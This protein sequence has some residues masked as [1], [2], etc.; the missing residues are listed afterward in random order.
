MSLEANPGLAELELA[1]PDAILVCWINVWLDSLQVQDRLGRFFAGY[2]SCPL[3]QSCFVGTF[4]PILERG[5]CTD[6]EKK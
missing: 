4:S 6:R 3:L 1:N 5:L 2:S